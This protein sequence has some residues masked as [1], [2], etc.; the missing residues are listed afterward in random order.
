MRDLPGPRLEP[1]SPALAGRFLNT[2]PPGK[3]QVFL[4]IVNSNKN[5]KY[6]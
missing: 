2:A 4:L 5:K 6:Y 1:V 3:S